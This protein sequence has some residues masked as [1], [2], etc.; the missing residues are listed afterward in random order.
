MR[1]LKYCTLIVFHPY[2][3]HVTY[4]DSGRAVPKDYT[5]VKYT[6]DKALN[7]FRAEVGQL[8]HEKKVKG[9]YVCN[10]VTNFPCL[11]QSSDDNGMDAW[12]AILQMREFVKDEQVLSLPAGLRKKGDDLA[13]TTDANVRAKFRAI[14]RK[15]GTI[16]KRDVLTRG[17]LFNYNGITL[18]NKEIESRLEAC[19][20]E[21]TF[22]TLEGVLPFPP[23]KT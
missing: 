11:K 12:F 17:A 7:G 9:C 1:R 2:H 23:K 6:L 18:T 13:N 10:H 3:S 15:I 16:L 14:Q 4:L 8:K 22:N 5:D 20:D 21:R 19:C